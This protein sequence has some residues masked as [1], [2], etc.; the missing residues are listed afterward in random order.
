MWSFV[1]PGNVLF[2]VGTAERFR[3]SVLSLGELLKK[4]KT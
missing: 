4:V 3:I 1:Y 2:V